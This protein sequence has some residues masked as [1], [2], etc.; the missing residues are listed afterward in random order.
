MI[1]RNES[2]R[3]FR[4]FFRG[5]AADGADEIFREIFAL[6]GEHAIVAG[7]FLHGDRS[8]LLL[9]AV[10]AQPG[11]GQLTAVNLTVGASDTK[12]CGYGDLMHVH[13]SITITA[14]EVNVRFGVG[15]E[16]FRT[17]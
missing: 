16:A 2:F 14:D 4:E 3:N 12:L 7:I 15:I 11:E 9:P 8:F 1:V 10:A 13:D 5:G 6:E 17:V